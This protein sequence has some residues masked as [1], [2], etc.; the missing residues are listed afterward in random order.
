MNTREDFTRFA[1]VLTTIS[2]LVWGTLPYLSDT[3]L[4]LSYSMGRLSSYFLA[5][6]FSLGLLTVAL[7]L[8]GKRFWAAFGATAFIVLP[9]LKLKFVPIYPLGQQLFDTYLA[10]VIIV[11]ANARELPPQ[12]VEV[13]SLP[14]LNPIRIPTRSAEGRL[15]ALWVWL[16][17]PRQWEVAEDWQCIVGGQTIDIPAG[18]RFDGASVPRPFWIL[19]TPIGILLV[20][21]LLHDYG[22]KYEHLKVGGGGKIGHDKNRLFWDKLFLQAGVDVNGFRVLSSLAGYAVCLFGWTAWF[23]H[24]DKKWLNRFYMLLALGIALSCICGPVGVT[25]VVLLALLICLFVFEVGVR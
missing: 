1:T 22:Y 15:S 14:K 25:C 12:Y 3:P 9:L 5:T 19:V 20:P 24:R 7:A 18:F 21:G 13:S 10:L 2:A 16:S 23:G 4:G 11:F 17:K 6:I 8:Q